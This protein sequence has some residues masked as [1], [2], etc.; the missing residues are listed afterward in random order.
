MGAVPAPCAA[1][2]S[3]ASVAA[4]G[5]AASCDAVA[6]DR[7]PAA[8]S[9][10]RTAP[11]A[12]PSQRNLY[13]LNLP[14]DA[15]STELESLFAPF[16]GVKHSVVLAMLDTQARRRGF[17]DMATPAAAAAAL[18]ALQGYVWRGYPMELSYAL[19]QRDDGAAAVSCEVRVGGLLPVA[20]I[21][22]D[23]VRA[24]V[25][26]VAEPVHVEMPTPLST[27]YTARVVLATAA[28]ATRVRDALDGTVRD[29]QHLVVTWY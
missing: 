12:A 19:V 13:A 27:P 25:A 23:D 21:D 1:P 26:P 29:G 11:A 18:D 28:E 9:S 7:A 17:V 4:G 6:A 14:L 22:A 8:S 24:L 10:S 16:G 5:A 15:T 20:T 2:R 3:W